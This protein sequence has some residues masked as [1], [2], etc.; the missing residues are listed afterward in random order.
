M[1]FGVVAII[2]TYNE[3]RFIGGCIEHL[4]ANGVEVVLCDNESSDGTRAIAAQHLGHGVRAIETIPRDGTY[5][6]RHILARKEQLATE[7]QAD[8]VMHLDA[9]EI[10]E[11]SRVGQTL[12]EA[13]AE[14]E[15]AGGN[16]VE[17][18]EATFVATAED[19]DHDHPEFRRTMRW[20]YPFAPNPL[21]LV[22]AWKR[23]THVDLLSTGGHQATFS[24]RRIAPV[25]HLLRHYLVLS[26][27]HLLRK[28]VHRQY[29]QGE[30]RR[31]WHGWRA[32]LTTDDLALPSQTELQFLAEG[33]TPNFSS[34]RSRHFLEW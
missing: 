15:A 28:Y 19:P 17:F 9:D 3:E 25:K 24:G 4:L 23:Q 6:W 20:Y 11:S 32:H 2:A 14:A 21:H 5:R 30:V 10:P 26:R 13:F 27:E 7:I 29:D 8:W 12:A 1:P 22:R 33:A 34:P 31:G 18:R 16:A